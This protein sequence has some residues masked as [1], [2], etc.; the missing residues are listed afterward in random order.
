MEG[1][2]REG[3]AREVEGGGDRRGGEV[4]EGVSEEEVRGVSQRELRGVSHTDSQWLG[5]VG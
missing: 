5:E 3:Y 1:Q 4:R 2:C